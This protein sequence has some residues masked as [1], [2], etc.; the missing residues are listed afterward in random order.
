M[1]QELY[2]IKGKGQWHLMKHMTSNVQSKPLIALK[3]KVKGPSGLPTHS[4]AT[5]PKEMDAIIRAAYGKIYDG[6][7]KDQ[8][9]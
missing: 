6:N 3:R 9:N 4:V 2:A 1:A 8:E 7:V 5:D